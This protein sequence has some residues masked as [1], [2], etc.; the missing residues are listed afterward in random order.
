MPQGRVMF[1]LQGTMK[2]LDP[3][4]RALLFEALDIRVNSLSLG[5]HTC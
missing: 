2:A 1:P 4:P 3:T 5:F